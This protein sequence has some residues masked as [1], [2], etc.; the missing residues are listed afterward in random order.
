MLRSYLKISL[1]KDVPYPP[2]L[3]STIKKNL[4]EKS[5]QRD[6]FLVLNFS[7]KFSSSLE[8]LGQWVQEGKLKTRENIVS[9]IENAGKAFVDMMNGGNIGKQLV[10]V[11][12]SY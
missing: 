10:Q 8:Q 5:I 6:R 3:S 4:E 1:I 9:G 2:P 12:G 11:D 7:D